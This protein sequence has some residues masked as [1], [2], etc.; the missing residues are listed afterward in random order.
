MRE[1]AKPT[2]QIDDDKVKVTRWDFSPGAETGW[3]RH[4]MDYVVVPLTFS[5][6]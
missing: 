3:H 2:V 5:P 6:L 4:E 1:K